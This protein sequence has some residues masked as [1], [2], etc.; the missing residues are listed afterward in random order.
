MFAL[1]SN[2]THRYTCLPKQVSV[3]RVTCIM[4][5]CLICYLLKV[6]VDPDT[7]DKNDL[8]SRN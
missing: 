1:A 8:S 4:F 5:I 7:G 2:V 6:S 3:I